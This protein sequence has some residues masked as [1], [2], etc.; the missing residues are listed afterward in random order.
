MEIKIDLII[1]KT[2]FYLVGQIRAKYF[3]CVFSMCQIRICLK[4]ITKAS[5]FAF[6]FTLRIVFRDRGGDVNMSI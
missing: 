5:S 2:T 3:F 4:L 6:H 1:S